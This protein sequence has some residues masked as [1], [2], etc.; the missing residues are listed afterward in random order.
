MDVSPIS[1]LVSISCA[2]VLVRF[3]QFKLFCS[4]LGLFA[5]VHAQDVQIRSTAHRKLPAELLLLEWYHNIILMLQKQ[6]LPWDL[7]NEGK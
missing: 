5:P 1:A 6:L 2:A 4:F 7:L 3:K